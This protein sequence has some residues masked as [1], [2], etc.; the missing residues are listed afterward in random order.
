[1]VWRLIMIETENDR[2]D[3]IVDLIN[4]LLDQSYRV[5]AK[6]KEKQTNIECAVYVDHDGNDA[7][8][9]V[10]DSKIVQITST[11]TFDRLA[12]DY[13]GDPNLGPLISYYNKI[14]YE[15]DLLSG[16]DVKIPILTKQESN[17][18][19]R[20]YASPQMQDNYGR[21][22]AIADDGDFAVVGGD[23]AV[24][25][26]PENLSQA[27]ANRLTTASEKRI[28]IGAYG[29]RAA[30]GDPM[31]INSYLLGS[32][33]QTVK[34]DPR[35]ERIDDIYFEGQRDALFILLTYTDINGN[36]DNYEGKI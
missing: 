14:Q 4:R 35:I 26:G 13:L 22:I 28:R 32:I 34:E 10:Y 25:S 19:N 9:Y 3:V 20:I 29:I 30:V 18:N 17:Q 8:A 36:R 16:I 23:L 1:M 15:H 27:I 33:E 6:A 5:M 31:A 21:D 11:T 24:A 7:I 12:R 2:Q